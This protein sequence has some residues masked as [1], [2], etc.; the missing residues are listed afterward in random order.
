MSDGNVA[1]AIFHSY[2]DAESALIQLHSAG[3]DPAKLSIVGRHRRN[4]EPES[5]PL[6]PDTGVESRLPDAVF[7]AKW[8]QLVYGWASFFLPDIGEILVAGPL[9][10]WMITVL[11]NARIFGELSVLGA[12]LYMVGVRKTL[13][14]RYEAALR[15]DRCLVVAHGSEDEIALAKRVLRNSLPAEPVI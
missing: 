12:G 2:R 10:T 3:F 6:N 11:E 13:A 4:G 7:G 8:R 15:N 5:P 14:L 1:V 9:A